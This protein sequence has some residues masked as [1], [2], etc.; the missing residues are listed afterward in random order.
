MIIAF[1][2]AADPSQ[3]GSLSVAHVDADASADADEIEAPVSVLSLVAAYKGD[4]FGMEL[5]QGRFAV[6]R[7][8]DAATLLSA[9][10]D[11]A[12][13]DMVVIA[14]GLLPAETINNT[15]AE[16]RRRHAALPVV[17]L[18]DRP[19]SDNRIDG[20]PESEAADERRD[21]ASPSSTI[22]RGDV[23]VQ[24]DHGRIS[25]KQQDVG[26]TLGEYKI[27]HLLVTSRGQFVTYR[28]L[29][30]AMHYRGFA[31]GAGSEGYR[32]NVRAVIKRI[33][34]KFRQIDGDFS[35]IENFQTFGYRW[36]ETES[37]GESL[38]PSD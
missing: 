16:L 20:T 1:Q 28:A 36:R 19:A 11:G 2:S 17:L 25:W 24:P 32:T 15:L 26:L 31:A 7:F 4:R 6:R 5:P 23:V 22:V 3:P 13:A 18:H 27:V 8:A 37:S 9:L 10:Q 34:L 38:T 33:R 21:V 30:D 12:K 35:R 14:A 29:Y